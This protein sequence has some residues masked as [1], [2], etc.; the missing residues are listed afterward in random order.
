LPGQVPFVGQGAASSTTSVSVNFSAAYGGSSATSY[1]IQYRVTGQTA[2][3][4]FGTVTWIGWQTVTGLAPG[5]SYDVR[6]Y[7]QNAYGSGLPSTPFTLSTLPLAVAAAQLPGP[8]PSIGAGAAST[9][10]TVSITFAAPYSGGLVTAYNIQYRATGQ[11]AWKAYGSV[12]WIGWQTLSGLTPGTSY[13][14]EV[15]ASNSAGNGGVSPVFTVATT[16]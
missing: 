3:T 16:P 14:V 6:V 11:T 4:T 10:T 8:I 5:T 15:Y 13:D 1:F 7:G 2:W 12:T 9:P